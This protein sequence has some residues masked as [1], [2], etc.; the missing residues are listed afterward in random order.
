MK[1]ETAGEL[2]AALKKA[3]ATKDKLVMLEVIADKHDI[4]PLLADISAA[5]KPK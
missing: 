4:P 5:L 2:K 1:V 3:A